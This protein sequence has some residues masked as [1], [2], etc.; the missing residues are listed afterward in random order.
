[1]LR[2]MLSGTC[3]SRSRQL[4]IHDSFYL[5]EENWLVVNTYKTISYPL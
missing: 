4:N 3:T 5:M 1:M 2:A